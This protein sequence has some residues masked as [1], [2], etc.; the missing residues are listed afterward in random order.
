[1]VSCRSVALEDTT[2]R[3]RLDS[4]RVTCY[5]HIGHD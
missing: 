4:V 5:D 3:Y 2:H 1:M